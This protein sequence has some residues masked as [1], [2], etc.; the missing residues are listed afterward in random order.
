MSLDDAAL[1]AADHKLKTSLSKA[2]YELGVVYSIGMQGKTAM[3]PDAQINA[4]R[5]Q[6]HIADVRQALAVLTEHFSEE[7]TET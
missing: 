6:R 3:L 2:S 4:R 5:A 7:E 1:E